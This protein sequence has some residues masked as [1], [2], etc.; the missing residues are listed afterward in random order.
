MAKC[1]YRDHDTMVKCVRSDAIFYRGVYLCP[2]H[3]HRML[4]PHGN[5]ARHYVAYYGADLPGFC[6]IAALP[7]GLIKIGSSR[8]PKTLRLRFS[9][10]SKDYGATIRPLTIL[11]GGLVAE[12]ALHHKFADAWLPGAGERFRLTP[13]LAEFIA[14]PRAHGYVPT[15]EYRPGPGLL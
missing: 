5:L 2:D 4:T 14:D 3:A 1:V 9:A 6:Y 15:M 7:G 12:M 13:E 11:H 10:L 8:D